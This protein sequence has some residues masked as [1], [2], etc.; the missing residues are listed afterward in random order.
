MSLNIEP[1]EEQLI[2][3][4]GAA[5]LLTAS[6]QDKEGTDL[7]GKAITWTSHLDGLIGTGKVLDFSTLPDLSKGNHVFTVT[8]TGLDGTTISVMKP[9]QINVLEELQAQSPQ[10]GQRENPQQDTPPIPMELSPVEEYVLGTLI[11]SGPP[12]SY[13]PEPHGPGPG[14]APLDPVLSSRMG[15]FVNPIEESVAIDD[16]GGP[17]F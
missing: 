12:P 15:N 16:F 5:F 14:G 10:Q 3:R 9:I 13:Y 17:V 6:A 8:A 1:N 4:R 7:T 2:L 11:P